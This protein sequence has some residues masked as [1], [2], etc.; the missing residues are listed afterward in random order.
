LLFLVVRRDANPKKAK[1]WK[2]DLV[3]MTR[4]VRVKNLQRFDIA[5]V[6]VRLD[7]VASLIVNV[8]NSVM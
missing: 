2:F 6:F 4:G 1:S 5:R 3:E 7:Q 8:D